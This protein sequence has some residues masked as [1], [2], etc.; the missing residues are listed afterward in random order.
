MFEIPVDAF[1]VWLGIATVGVVTLGVVTALPTTA[2]P[3]ATAVADSIDRVAVEPPGAHA[4]AQVDA[5]QF[6]IG[7]HRLW[8]RNDG[9]SAS[10][11]FAYGPVT[12][13]HTDDRLELLLYGH[14]P[15]AVFETPEAFSRVV[16]AAQTRSEWRP[17]PEVIEV[18]RVEWGE[19]DVTLVG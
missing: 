4:T 8:L 17:A 7:P 14:E 18:R 6:R 10:A 3:D 1:Y 19:T 12:P 15:A 16:E 5:S 2:P 9:G 13:V 11:S